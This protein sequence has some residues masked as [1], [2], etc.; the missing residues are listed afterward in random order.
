[1]QSR[2]DFVSNKKYTN[3][4]LTQTY[5]DVGSYIYTYIDVGRW[6]F[7][8]KYHE[9]SWINSLLHPTFGYGSWKKVLKNL[10]A[11]EIIII[12][13]PLGDLCFILYCH[14]RNISNEDVYCLL[15]GTNFARLL[16]SSIIKK[17]QGAPIDS[18]FDN[19]F[20]F[21]IPIFR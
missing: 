10:Y 21:H 6:F 11:I 1:M 5:I 20:L 19:F 4:V 7:C 3:C 14:T 15:L 9:I 8:V 17:I 18:N 13:T 2:L 16:K 12:K